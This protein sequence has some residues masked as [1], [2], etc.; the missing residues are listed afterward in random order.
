MIKAVEVWF[1]E[2]DKTFLFKAVVALHV[3]FSKCIQFRGWSV[4]QQTTLTCMLI[5]KILPRDSCVMN[6]EHHSYN[7]VLKTRWVLSFLQML[8]H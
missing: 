6:G 8:E 7:L 4:E 2:Q 3:N 1:A 5:F